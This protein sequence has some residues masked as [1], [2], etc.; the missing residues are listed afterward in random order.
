MIESLV[1]LIHASEPEHPLPGDL[2]EEYMKDH[3]KLIKN[4]EDYTKKHAKR[5]PS[6]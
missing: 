4:A 1:S 2:A 5:Q 3:K 6:D